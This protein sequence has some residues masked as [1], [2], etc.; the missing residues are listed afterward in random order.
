MNKYTLL[1]GHI[2]ETRKTKIYPTE[3]IPA[4]Q[5]GTNRETVPFRWLSS[6]V[7]DIK[8]VLPDEKDQKTC[9]VH[10]V[11]KLTV[12]YDKVLTTADVEA[13]KAAELKKILAE[14]RDTLPPDGST[15]NLSA[16]Q[17]RELKQKLSKF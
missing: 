14:L 16:D 12:T 4:L 17:L 10:G 2:M 13:E 15:L 8:R 3:K 5:Q 9:M 1:G 6:L 11:D 7:D